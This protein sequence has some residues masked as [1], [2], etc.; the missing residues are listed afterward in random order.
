MKKIM[1]FLLFFI[2]I[3]L[4]LLFLKNT[5]FSQPDI[6]NQKDWEKLTNLT[7]S[8]DGNNKNI[9]I[10][11]EDY[12]C[13]DCKHLN[14]NIIEKTH[15]LKQKNIEI[16]HIEMSFLSKNSLKVSSAANAVKQFSKNKYDKFHDKMI[17]IK[18]KNNDNID[19]VIEKEINDL[20]VKKSIKKEIIRSYKNKNSMAWKKARKE[21]E[22]SE[23]YNIKQ[24]PSVYL[25]GN[26]IKHVDNK[27]KFE[28]EVT[29]YISE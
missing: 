11:F 14:N 8:N 23:K 9:L 27:S 22:I 20:N 3:L 25:N 15:V 7:E 4:I 1:I 24:A 13:P 16:R 2:L 6:N 21:K 19:S 5:F 17:N 29:Q 10:I 12:S 28:N 26:E 18:V